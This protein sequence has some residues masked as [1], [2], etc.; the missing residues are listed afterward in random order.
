MKILLIIVI[1]VGCLMLGN[2]IGAAA[3]GNPAPRPPF[4][5]I[6]DGKNV[7]NPALA[8]I[9]DGH[10]LRVDA[11]STTQP[12]TGNV[13]VNGNVTAVGSPSSGKSGTLQ[14][15][16]SSPD[17]GYPKTLTICDDAVGAGSTIELSVDGQSWHRLLQTSGPVCVAA[18]PARFV[19][20]TTSAGGFY[21]ASY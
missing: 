8:E 15:G 18:P 9:T 1:A 19:R 2:F 20:I 16:R 4:V 14:D 11:S 13:T 6:R 7:P 12:V 21:Q 10:A 5:I 3:Q 17:L